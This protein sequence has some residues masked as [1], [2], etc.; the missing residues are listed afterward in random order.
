MELREPFITFWMKYIPMMKSVKSSA[1]RDLVSARLQIAPS[2][3]K[4]S[5][6]RT[7]ISLAV[8]PSRTPFWG[9][10]LAKMRV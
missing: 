5:L 4:G 9:P 10:A 7:K 6:L 8:S 2:L 3:S 1:P